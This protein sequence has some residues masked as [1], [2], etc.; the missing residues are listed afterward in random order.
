MRSQ[1]LS[2]PRG[3]FARIGS[4]SKTNADAPICRSTCAAAAAAAAVVSGAAAAARGLD[5]RRHAR[6]QA[7]YS[8]EATLVARSVSCP[9]PA[10]MAASA[11]RAH[12]CVLRRKTRTRA[13][14]GVQ[15]SRRLGRT[16]RRGGD[17]SGSGGGRAGAAADGR[18]RMVFTFEPILAKPPLGGLWAAHSRLRRYIS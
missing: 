11:G 6:R 7:E 13:P 5:A 14:P 4:N 3:G 18:V 17:R 9:S 8:I 1:S 12:A 2:P 10:R 15:A 16:G